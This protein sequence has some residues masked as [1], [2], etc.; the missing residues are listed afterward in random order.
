[1]SL[2][3]RWAIVLVPAL[4]LYFLP[5]PG[6]NAGQRHLL[7]IFVGT[8]ISLVAQPVVMGVSVLVAM[9]I[10]VL[11]N[12][13][14]GTKVL[15]GFSNATVWL[16]FT[17]FLFARAITATGFGLRIAYLLSAASATARS[18]WDIR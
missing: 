18:R 4:L 15:S 17:A 12:T 3:T 10:L 8:I 14:P 7:A 2:R 11:T 5:V 13:V 16:I 1:M 6:L 9:T